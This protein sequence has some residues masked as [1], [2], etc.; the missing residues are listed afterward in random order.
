M[1]ILP[2][3]EDIKFFTKLT[4]KVPSKAFFK[5]LVKDGEREYNT[6]LE[7]FIDL[8]LSQ[9]VPD[10]IIKLINDPLSRL[11]LIKESNSYHNESSTLAHSVDVAEGLILLNKY[12][13]EVSAITGLIHDWG[14]I[15]T[16]SEKE[17]NGKIITQ[18]IGHAKEGYEIIMSIKD[19]LKE[20]YE[21]PPEIID[22]IATIVKYH[23]DPIDL[24]NA[25]KTAKD[26][27]K[28]IQNALKKWG[29]Y[30]D[31]ILTFSQ[32]DISKTPMAKEII[33]FYQGLEEK[34]LKTM[35]RKIYK[36]NFQ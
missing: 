5:H 13:P 20:K 26:P 11:L 29:P 31:E 3:E 6:Q 17:K 34:Y 1:I 28:T 14:K 9:K 30:S 10:K 36:S 8:A 27:E 33:E 19:Y 35:E 16:L 18:A 23:M 24:Y 15:Y 4:G 21:L 7:R 22:Y 12:E 32:A 2:S 25:M